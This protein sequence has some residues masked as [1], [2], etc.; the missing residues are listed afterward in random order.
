MISYIVPL[1]KDGR[2]WGVVG[3]DVDFDLII[4]EVRK[5][6]PYKTGYAFLTSDTGKIYYHPRYEE[7]TEL[8][9]NIP[10]LADFTK[11]L[12][13]DIYNDSN[14]CYL[15]E[16]NGVAKQLAHCSLHN[17]MV[18]MISAEIR[19][20]NSSRDPLL[21]IIILTL[22]I[23]SLVS[24]MFV[25]FISRRI[26]QPLVKLTAAADQIARGNLDVDLPEAGR[27]EVGSLTKSFALTVKSLKEYI[28]GMNTKAYRDTLT[29][30][31]NRA[32][33]EETLA[34]LGS[35]MKQ[36][37]RQFALLM[38]DLND[39]KKINDQHGHDRGNDYLVN[40]C[41]MICHVFR[42]SPVFRI[43]GDE[44]IAILQNEDLDNYKSLL[45]ELEKR[46]A[47]TQRETEPWKVI[48]VAKGI[49][50]CEDGDESPDSV[51]KRADENMYE[52]KHR[53][54]KN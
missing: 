31:R 23:G 35:Q 6:N 44:F 1:Y 51:F 18:L 2:F 28:A 33:F 40:S 19:E 50:F 10:P 54:K 52:D 16:E 37:N 4:N 13:A 27:D 30:V 43:G 39:L 5:I 9:D 53:M 41:R 8:A 21:S 3:M 17:G 11:A 47:A 29:H 49:A 32:A 15:F 14:D 46:M 22:L 42:H 12:R 26:T 7:G 48:S 45:E 36:G 20:I 34:E 25:M 24:A 38:L